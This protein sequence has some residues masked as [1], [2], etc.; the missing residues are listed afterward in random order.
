L[1]DYTAPTNSVIA[2]AENALQQSDKTKLFRVYHNPAKDVLH[3]ET[4]GTGTFS[5]LNQSGKI[6]LSTNINSKGSIHIPGIAAG[7]YYLRNN[8]RGSVQKIVI[9]R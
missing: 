8:S 7:L 5:L 6:L 1:Y 3:V 9:A 2:S 4:S